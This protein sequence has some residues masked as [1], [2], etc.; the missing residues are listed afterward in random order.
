MYFNSILL[1]YFGWISNISIYIKENK[2][3]IYII[4]INGNHKK[5]FVIVD[6]FSVLVVGLTMTWHKQVV[7]K[8]A[9][10][11]DQLKYFKRKPVAPF[12]T[13][14]VLIL[15]EFELAYIL[16]PWPPLGQSLVQF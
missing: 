3:D 16:I 4:K 10:Y 1:I 7:L 8:K 9:S 14:C 11:V 5:V 6:M 13:E 15:P 12:C 2:I